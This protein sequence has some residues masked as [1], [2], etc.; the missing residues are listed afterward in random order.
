M[1]SQPLTREARIYLALWRKALK[2]PDEPVSITVSSYSTALTVRSGMYRAIRPYRFGEA[3]DAELQKAAEQ[4]VVSVTK[5]PDPTTPH[6]LILKPRLSLSELEAE[7]HNLG[8]D[9]DDLLLEEERAVNKKLAEFITPET[10]EAPKAAP[11][12]S[13]PFYSRED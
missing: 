10:G 7:F 5:N 6:K 1:S 3:F 8:L 4:F 12:K 11:R 13:N 9:E 2:S